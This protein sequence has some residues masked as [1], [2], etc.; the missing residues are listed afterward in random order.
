MLSP[1]MQFFLSVTNELKRKKNR[2][3][4]IASFS[5]TEEGDVRASRWRA[6]GSR[7][8]QSEVRCKLCHATEARGELERGGSRSR[9]PGSF[10]SS[11]KPLNSR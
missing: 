3:A 1:T 11:L 7:R 6:E 2:I 9:M 8:S 4:R 10:H 5:F